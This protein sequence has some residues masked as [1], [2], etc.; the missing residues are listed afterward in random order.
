[1]AGQLRVWRAGESC[2]GVVVTF[3]SFPCETETHLSSL[4][5]PATNNSTL[6]NKVAIRFSARP[7]FD[8]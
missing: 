8:P 3:Q 5:L 6:S 4:R 1:M 2:G 7:R